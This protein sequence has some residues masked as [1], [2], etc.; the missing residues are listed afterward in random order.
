MR[1]PIWSGIATVT[2]ALALLSLVGQSQAGLPVDGGL[3]CVCSCPG[4]FICAIES[5]AN[6]C[7][8]FC[9]GGGLNSTAC[10]PEFVNSS[11]CAT[12]LQC[13]AQRQAPALG[14]AT[15]TAMALALAALGVFGL[16]RAAG[17]KRA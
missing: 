10:V 12:V 5:T 3:C 16:R 7:R 8:E 2:L 6:G 9:A 1:V 4:R 11:S 15:L 14:N 13:T 17:R